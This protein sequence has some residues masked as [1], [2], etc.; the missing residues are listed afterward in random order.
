LRFSNRPPEEMCQTKAEM[1]WLYYLANNN[2]SVS[3]PLAADNNNLVISTQDRGESFIISAFEVLHGSFWD[4]NNPDLWNAKIFFNWGKVMG[5]IHKLTKTYSPAND[6]DV[7]GIFTGYNALEIDKIKNCPSVYQ[8]AKDTISEIMTLPKDGDSYGLIHY[9][10]HPWNFV[11]NGEQI[12]V[13]DFD[14][15]LYGWF[16]LD[17]GIVYITGFGGDAKTTRDMTLPTK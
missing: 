16:A 4:K 17:I 3:L 5:D 11:I 15:S 7:R 12:S 8:I 9:D 6:R 13:F 2:I 10:I 1:D 14:D